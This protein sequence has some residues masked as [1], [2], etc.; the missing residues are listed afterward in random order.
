VQLRDLSDVLAAA[1][2]FVTVHV[3]AESAVE[4]AAD[5][6]EMT[7]KSI[8]KRLEELDVPEPVR[9]AVVAAKGEHAEG[10]ARLVVASVPEA[11][12][13]LSEPVSSR[14]ATDVVDVASLPRLLPLV[15]DLTTQVPHVV[16]H[17]DRT[18]ADVVAYY[19]TGKVT[20]EVTV[21][22]RTL[23]LRK[24]QGGG[25][26]HLHYQHRAE[27][28]WRENAK[29]IRETTM[30]LAEQVGAELIVGVGDERELTYVKEGLAQPWDGLWIEVPG[31]RSQDG[32]EQLVEQRVR[33]AV[34]LHTA[35]EALTLLADYAQERGQD[36]R[37]ADGLPDVVEALRKAQVQ[38]LV[39]TTDADE[40][41]TL[42]FGEDP[43]QLGTRRED[44]EALGATSPTEGPMVSV[45][46]RAALAT[47][48]DVQIVPHQS[49][50]APQSGVGALL[51]YADAD[52]GVGGGA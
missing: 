46:L 26:A 19:D 9:E 12:V 6:Y 33:D 5:R 22:G 8:A 44:V 42:W 36:K 18:G 34:S 31:G 27:N 32:S 13:L 43:T 41:S 30:Q 49:E 14:P 23:H 40:H 28:Q 38:T 15:A 37:A 2:P 51:R 4:Q 20:E 7:W 47:G 29:E 45:L 17:A 35:A 50:Q 11:R 25:W 39:L 21:K 16:V 24:V 10:P 48:A 3:G 52:A 1:G